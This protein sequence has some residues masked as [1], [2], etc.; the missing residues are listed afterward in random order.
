MLKIMT[1]LQKKIID[2]IQENNKITKVIMVEKT[3]VS[4]TTIKRCIKTSSKIFYVGSKKGGH[5]KV[6]E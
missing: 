5:W 3:G 6:K 1:K 4:K 2:L